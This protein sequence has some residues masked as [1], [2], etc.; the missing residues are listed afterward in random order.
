VE[1]ILAAMGRSPQ[2]HGISRRPIRN[3][4]RLPNAVTDDFFGLD[5]SEDV[6]YS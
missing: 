4:P 2:P 1:R 6:V 3:D 5:T